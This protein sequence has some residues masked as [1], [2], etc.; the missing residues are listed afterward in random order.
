MGRSERHKENHYDKSGPSEPGNIPV[1]VMDWME[2]GR[3]SILDGLGKKQIYSPMIKG[4]V[5]IL[6]RKGR[7][8]KQEGRG[9]YRII[10]I[11]IWG[12]YTIFWITTTYDLLGTM[13][14]LCFDNE[15]P[16]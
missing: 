7:D 16:L 4:A 14:N 5:T 1:I 11:I 6:F 2:Y 13:P 15:Q 3:D 9:G 12:N 10:N 8:L